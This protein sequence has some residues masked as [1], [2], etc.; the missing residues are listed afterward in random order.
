MKFIYVVLLIIL[1][2]SQIF[3]F[4]PLCEINPED[5]CVLKNFSK[6]AYLDS[7]YIDESDFQ[8]VRRME[9]D[10]CNREWERFFFDGQTGLSEGVFRNVGSVSFLSQSG[11]GHPVIVIS[12]HGSKWIEDWLTDLTFVPAPASELADNIE[13]HIHKGFLKTTISSFPHLLKKLENLPQDALTD[14]EIYFTGHS[15]GG[16][17]AALSALKL[18]L[19]YQEVLKKPNQIKVLTFSAPHVGCETFEQRYYNF[20][21]KENIINFRFGVDIVP[22]LTPGIIPYLYHY[23]PIGLTFDTTS[24]A[25]LYAN[26]KE[27]NLY[28]E[29]LLALLTP[30]IK[31]SYRNHA[32]ALN[33]IFSIA[34][35]FWEGYWGG[36][37]KLLFRK[38]DV[39]GLF[40]AM[41]SLPTDHLIYHAINTFKTNITRD[42][43]SLEDA[44]RN[45]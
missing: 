12:Y 24:V 36:W 28:E 20:V 34:D 6:Q 13:G 43:M 8:I 10:I 37:I 23:V 39:A 16:A 7:E 11:R 27:K 30:S 38:I 25:K 45:I 31:E 40:V 19:Y 32:R 29:A 1:L 3:A 15:L 21:R 41:H 2:P 35:F 5:A 18:G 14:S 26:D 9:V 4:D 42:N 44:G 33:T 17:L 22:R